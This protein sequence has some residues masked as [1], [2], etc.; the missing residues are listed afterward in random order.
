M[1]ALSYPLIQVTQGD[2]DH[3][4]VVDYD[5]RDW[6]QFQGPSSLHRAGNAIR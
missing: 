3:S 6:P 5:S 2:V 1:L 4:E